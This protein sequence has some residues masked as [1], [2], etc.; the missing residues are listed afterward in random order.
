LKKDWSRLNQH[1]ETQVP[2]TRVPEEL[3]APVEAV[4][5]GSRE[6][7]A[8][9]RLQTALAA[10]AELKVLLAAAKPL[11][12]A[13]LHQVEDLTSLEGIQAALKEPWKVSPDLGRLE[14]GVE[15]FERVT[16]SAQR[17]EELRWALAWK[18]TEAGQPE[19]ARRLLRDLK[20]TTEGVG[21]VPAEGAAPMPPIVAAVP[22][23]EAPPGVRMVPRESALAALPALEKETA[24]AVTTS[25]QAARGVLDRQIGIH[26]QNVNH[27]L[28]TIQQYGKRGDDARQ[29]ERK[30][31]DPYAA[32]VGLLG[33]ALAPSER[34][35][36]RA[37][38]ARGQSPA[39]IAANLRALDKA[40]E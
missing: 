34:I 23:P 36:A 17:T 25:R 38:Q 10:D 18:A 8:L 6:L 32:V 9:T 24:A 37:M 21:R 27:A 12:G 16:G 14:K 15:T 7:D 39:E 40:D 11:K 1:L 2:R 19:V 3:R 20:K 5:S 22:L 31:T 13:V 29:D 30:Q 33:R 26:T 35:L 4:E 28:R